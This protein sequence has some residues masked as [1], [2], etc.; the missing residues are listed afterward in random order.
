MRLL[1]T[2]D[3]FESKKYAIDFLFLIVEEYE[4]SNPICLQSQ[5][6]YSTIFECIRIIETEPNFDRAKFLIRD[7]A[8]IH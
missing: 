8:T 2:L 3:K 7:L 1:Q 5:S 6:F 4:K